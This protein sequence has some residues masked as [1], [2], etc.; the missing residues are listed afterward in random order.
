MKSSFWQAL[1]PMVLAA[2]L[3]S[4]I[5]NFVLL[6]PPLYMLQVYDRVLTTRHEE[7]LWVLTFGALAALA[8]SALLDAFRARLLTGA[9]IVLDRAYGP[10]LLARLV[11]ERSRGA[12]GDFAAGLGDFAMVKTF[13]T[14]PNVFLLYDVPWF[15]LFVALIFLFHP[16][17]GIVSVVGALVLVLLAVANERVS[18]RAIDAVRGQ[19]RAAGR[20]AEAALRNAEAVAAMGMQ[21][22]VAARWRD[23]SERSFGALALISERG[24]AIASASR[25]WRQAL[26]VLMLGVGALLVIEQQV[27]SGAMIAATIVLSRALAPVEMMVGNWR[28]IV[29]AWSAMQRLRRVV[30]RGAEPAASFELPTPAGRIAVDGVGLRVPGRDAPLVHGVTF[31]IEPG[32]LLGVV[33]PSAAGKTTL[34]RLMVGLW[35]PGIGSVRVDGAD[36]STWPREQLGRFIGY[37]PQ[38][39]ELFSGTVAENIARLEPPDS[40]R[41]IAAAQRARCHDMILQLPQGYDAEVGPEGELLTPGQRQRVALARALYVDLRF[42][43]LDE[44][45][46]NLDASGEHALMQA[47]RWL[48]TNG[49]TTVLITHHPALLSVVDRLLVMRDGTIARFGPRDEVLAWLS[50][51]PRLVRVEPGHTGGTT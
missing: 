20:Y 47:L 6:V 48:K 8:V 22:A 42:A 34:A 9:A 39:V 31:S 14:S 18:R 36:V 16:V 12:R 15:P 5:V 25:F 44:P 26:Q 21:H 43:V 17:L 50:Q 19:G 28:Q 24:G 7:T 35:K 1:R 40:P 33:G 2:A 41:V 13:L 51:G 45:N 32:E 27:T 49:I 38:D 3:F 46:A 10:D 4:V 29:D 30:D 11:T 23:L 37:V